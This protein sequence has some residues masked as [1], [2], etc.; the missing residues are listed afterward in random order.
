MIFFFSYSH[1]DSLPD[2]QRFYA[3]LDGNIRGRTGQQ[4]APCSFMDTNIPNGQPWPTTILE[5]LSRCRLIVCAFSPHFFQSEYCAKELGI[6]F[7]RLAVYEAVL[8]R[9]RGQ[10]SSPSLIF[11]VSWIPLEHSDVQQPPC[12]QDIHISGSTADSDYRK[13]GLLALARTAKE[14]YY[15][16]LD[17]LAEDML[18]AWRDLQG[19]EKN[20]DF[21]APRV[22]PFETAKCAFT[23]SGPNA[24]SAE[25]LPP[26]EHVTRGQPDDSVRARAIAIS[27]ESRRYI[28]ALSDCSLQVGEIGE[29]EPHYF[30]RGHQGEVR[31]VAMSRNGRKAISA[32]F[33]GTLKL[34]EL[35]ETCGYELGALRGHSNSAR[36]VVLSSDEK[37]AVSGSADRSLKIWNLAKRKAW[38]PERVVS[39]LTLELAHDWIIN[40]VA[41]TENVKY[42]L[43][44]SNDRTVRVWKL[45]G[46]K[47]PGKPKPYHQLTG[48][49]DYVL[50]VAIIDNQRAISASFDHILRIWNYKTGD[51]LHTLHEH[52]AQVRAVVVTSDRR[53]AVSASFDETV[54]VW[55]LNTSKVVQTIDGDCGFSTCA[56]SA[57]E[58]TILTGDNKRRICFYPFEP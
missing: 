24:T 53:Y 15:A 29:S 19:L 58:K 12:A 34:W 56:L 37:F 6:Y 9:M 4:N 55:D 38:Y 43:S 17:C 54:R 18:N 11:P 31:S 3:D 40:A 46:K 36:T 50:D 20:P 28:A 26:S 57:D 33:D 47:W 35:D 7:D 48:H 41:I 8:T 10:V 13:K 5:A 32:S 22:P 14:S 30:I 25:S 27:R 39:P 45:R 21:K 42:L 16:I 23:P 44:A 49:G 52:E 2:L 51:L 1:N